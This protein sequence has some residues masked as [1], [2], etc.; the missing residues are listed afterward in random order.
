MQ[1]ARSHQSRAWRIGFHQ[2]TIGRGGFLPSVFICRYVSLLPFRAETIQP[3]KPVLAGI[4]RAGRYLWGCAG[5]R[6]QAGSDV[7]LTGRV[8]FQPAHQ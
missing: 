8:N 4:S 1:H 2:Q 3:L 5:A 6:L 7:N